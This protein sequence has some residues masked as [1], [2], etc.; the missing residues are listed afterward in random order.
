MRLTYHCAQAE[1]GYRTVDLNFAGVPNRTQSRTD[2]TA[3]Q[4]HFFQWR[5]GID[6]GARDLRQNRILGHGRATHK[7]ID[8]IAILILEADRSVGHD[9]LTLRGSNRGAQVGLWGL[10]K[11]A[12]CLATLWSIRWNDM[13]SRC[14]RGDSFADGL[15]DTACFVAENAREQSFGIESVKGINIRM[16]DG[17]RHDLDTDFAGLWGVHGDR[18]FHQWLLGCTGN[19]CLAC[20]RFSCSLA[21]RIL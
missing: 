2:T 5:L 17:I 9:T 11:D 14:D 15:Y 4:T 3:K 19:H 1:N 20:D 8:W 12:R 13:I 6:L 21:H 7:M 18:F 16:T 10:A